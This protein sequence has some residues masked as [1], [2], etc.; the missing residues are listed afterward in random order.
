M[1]LL[2]VGIVALAIGAAHP[3]T[4]QAQSTPDAARSDSTSQGTPLLGTSSDRAPSDSTA[5]DWRLVLD[6]AP[7]A[8]PFPAPHLAPDSVHA[9]AQRFLSHLQRNGY[10]YATV[11]SAVIAPRL[12]RPPQ[13]MLYARRGP[14]VR[15]GTLRVDGAD[16]LPRDRIRRLLDTREGEP[17]NADRLEADIAALLREYAA[18]GRPLAQVR[19]SEI[20]LH[21]KGRAGV[22][23]TL[24]VTLRIKEGPTVQLQRVEVPPPS[25]TSPRLVAHLARL[26]LG[27]PLR[28]YDLEAIRER[29]QQ[30]DLFRSVAMP[31][32]RMTPE[33][34]ATLVVPVKEAAPGA[35]D[36][37]LGYLPPSGGR[38][39]G[40]LVG[41]GHLSLQ[42][43]F[44]GGRTGEIELDRRP[45]QVSLFEANVADPYVLNQPLRL[46]GSF[47][48]EQRDSTF[49]LRRFRLGAGIRLD[50]TLRLSGTLTREVT[51][52]GQAGTELVPTDDGRLQQRIPRA[53]I[54]FFGIGVRY[55]R[56]DR[57]VNPRSG[58]WV[59][60][61][62]EQGAK[63]RSRRVVSAGD[64]LRSRTTD[65][66]ERLQVA[67]RLFVPVQ[68]RQV[69][70]LG[71]E[72]SV[73]RSD[74]FD[75]SDLFRIGGAS[76]LRGYDE[77]RF[78]GNIVARGLLEYR[79][80]LSR[81]SY[82]YAFG[83][84]GYVQRPSIDRIAGQRGWHPGFGIG[85]QM[86]TA[87]GLINA[88]YALG[89]EDATP[90]NGRVHLG[91][92]VGL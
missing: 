41:S 16:R 32:L 70:V 38:S 35:F 46:D 59:D 63:N 65:R 1:V 24:A 44:G 89:T 29:L 45:G 86:D 92:S 67:G 19:V 87:L 88:S 51:R 57:P 82:T 13:V 84:L 73:L 49:S 3:E 68:S 60:V 83:D 26:T 78:T 23:P 42:N 21:T 2:L 43:V 10:Y 8:W 81:R 15:V 80:Q 76:S 77:D 61:S 20:A 12:V 11:D 91:L 53:E 9:V 33:G 72:A 22:E 48:G 18:E 62:V 79:L 64:T 5:A 69:L 7:S 36:V 71:G 74:T 28:S 85:I 30:S 50:R 31:R 55:E 90:A 75:T 47:R 17:L 25:R 4:A 34:D 40:Q 37:V 54:V 66:Q 56:M 27:D 39:S 52:P 6:R 14:Q 58:G